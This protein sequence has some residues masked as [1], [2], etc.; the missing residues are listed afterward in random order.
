MKRNYIELGLIEVAYLRVGSNKS[1]D[2]VKSDKT[3][4]WL[5]WSKC[6]CVGEYRPRLSEIKPQSSFGLRSTAYCRIDEPKTEPRRKVH[7]VYIRR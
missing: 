3:P 6:V 2:I 5:A 7:F 1:L 4:A